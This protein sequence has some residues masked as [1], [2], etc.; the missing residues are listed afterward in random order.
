MNRASPV[1]HHLSL[2]PHVSDQCR[3]PTYQPRFSSNDAMLTSC[4][5]RDRASVGDFG[6]HSD[7]LRDLVDHFG[8]LTDHVGELSDH[9]GDLS[10]HLRDLSDQRGNLS[11][12]FTSWYTTP[13]PFMPREPITV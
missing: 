1:S 13:G 11:D 12:H 7:H 9:F 10:D 4:R 6:D 2:D 3:G 5:R 8:D